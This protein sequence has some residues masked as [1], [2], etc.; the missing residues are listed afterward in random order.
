VRSS[1]SD[2]H[3]HSPQEHLRTYAHV[4]ID[5]RELDHRNLLGF[6]QMMQTP[7]LSRNVK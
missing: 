5:R 1:L 4:L 6:E 7:V 2:G 3:G